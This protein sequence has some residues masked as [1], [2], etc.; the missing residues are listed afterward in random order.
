M[1][2]G[3]I[4]TSEQIQLALILSQNGRKALGSVGMR[5]RIGH[6]QNV[7]C[8]PKGSVTGGTPKIQ[9]S[10]RAMVVGSKRILF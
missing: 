2:D 9:I 1:K 10:P 5:A 3:A 6:K 8:E 4:A 7:N